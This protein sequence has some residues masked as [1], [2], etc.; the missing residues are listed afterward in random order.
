M[1]VRK[2]KIRRNTFKR[3]NRQRRQH[4]ID[5][6]RRILLSTAGLLAF[7]AFNLVLILAHD[8]ITQTALLPIEEVQVEG[9]QRLSAETVRRRADI[10]AGGNILAVNLGVARRRL[11]AHPWI[12]GV[13]VIRE[14]P[15]RIIIRI[16]EQDC[17]A[18]LHLDRQFLVNPDG[19]IF[20]ERRKGEC[21]DVPLVSGLDYADLR[22][23]GRPAGP[24]LTAAMAL[25][26]SLPDP[27]ILGKQTKI[28]EIRVDQELG[29]TLFVT[30]PGT[31]P[32]HSTII[33]GFTPWEK[34][35]Q[36]LSAVQAYLERRDLV[37]GGPI[38]NLRTPDRIVISPGTGAATAGSTKEV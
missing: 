7:L 8:W 13:R 29:L 15:D 19:L 24:P 22:I 25:L 35:Y 4:R 17:R 31:Q 27:K 28:Q 14:I 33:L 10:H 32:P 34:K 6:I 38:F 36:K 2:R 23:A 26:N 16:R 18:V 9:V 1:V 5:H 11:E 37:P 12:A 20:K 30:R 3:G 21:A